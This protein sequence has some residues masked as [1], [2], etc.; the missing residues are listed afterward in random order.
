MNLLKHDNRFVTSEQRKKGRQQKNIQFYQLLILNQNFQNWK[1]QPM[2]GAT[3]HARK[4]GLYSLYTFMFKRKYSILQIIIP[5]AE[6]VLSTTA[7]MGMIGALRINPRRTTA[8]GPAKSMVNAGRQSCFGL[9][10]ISGLKRPNQG[11]RKNHPVRSG[12][13]V[14]RIRGKKEIEVSP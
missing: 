1:H 11:E 9:E 10:L 13:K 14:V 7:N 5:N 12:M 8:M 6:V 4:Y 2:G 3:H